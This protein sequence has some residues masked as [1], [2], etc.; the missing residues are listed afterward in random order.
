MHENI[1][2]VSIGITPS[3][4]TIGTLIGRFVFDIASFKDDPH[5][6]WTKSYVTEAFVQDIEA[7]TEG[8]PMI[9]TGMLQ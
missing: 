6:G 1:L 3:D 5:S 8:H 2:Q 9:P 7:L 4:R